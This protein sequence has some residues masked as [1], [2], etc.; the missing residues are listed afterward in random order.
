MIDQM[1]E[2]DGRRWALSRDFVSVLDAASR[3]LSNAVVTSSK[4]YVAQVVIKA[5]LM[6]V[7]NM[8]GGPLMFTLIHE[9]GNVVAK[10]GN[11]DVEGAYADE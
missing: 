11:F 2:S 9:M 1:G 5:V 4:E 8:T 7:E 10:I 6:Q 3:D